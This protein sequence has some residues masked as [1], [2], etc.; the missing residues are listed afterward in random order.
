M[1][2]NGKTLGRDA[3]T[4][5]DPLESERISSSRFGDSAVSQ[6]ISRSSS[7]WS[8][9]DG[10]VDALSALD[11]SGPEP[12]QEAAGTLIHE[13]VFHPTLTA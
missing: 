11:L 8:R 1:D 6:N 10:C 5:Q 4:G 3:E 9:R 13:P 7:G 2:W 12:G